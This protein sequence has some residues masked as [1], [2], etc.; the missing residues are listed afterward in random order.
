LN[1]KDIECILRYFGVK[2]IFI[3]KGILGDKMTLASSQNSKWNCTFEAP[4]RGGKVYICRSKK[5]K[6]YL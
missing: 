3:Y 4:S 5:K 6:V 2:H 1:E